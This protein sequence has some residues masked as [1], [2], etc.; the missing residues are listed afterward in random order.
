MP[1]TWFP[2]L[3]LDSADLPEIDRQSLE[4]WRVQDGE[5]YFS[6]GRKLKK[7]DP[8]SFE[9]LINPPSHVARDKDHIYFASSLKTSI[10]RGTFEPLGDFYFRDINFAY[11]EFE[12]SLQILKGRDA[13]N[14]ESLGC[15]YGRDSHFGYF[16]GRPLRKC[17]SPMSLKLI[18]A[19]NEKMMDYAMDDSF[20]Y[21]EGAAIKGAHLAT[22]EPHIRG[23]SVDR[24]SVFYDASP[25]GRVDRESW[26]HVTSCYSRDKKH[27]YYM[28]WRIEQA[29]VTTWH[30][31]GDAYS[32]DGERIFHCGDLI[33]HADASTFE[34]TPEGVARDRLGTFDRGERVNLAS[35]NPS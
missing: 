10:D 22:W 29:N 27:V 32:T 14:F 8:F 9:V 1:P 16:W 3:Q 34:I 24:K 12:T 23:F 13:K 7:A 33:P 19:S 6:G 4:C 11:C 20:V 28:R 17:Q 26:E 2:F 18:P 5:L 35:D 30:M 31:L 15:G 25:I 21:S